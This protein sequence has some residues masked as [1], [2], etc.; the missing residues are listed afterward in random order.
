[1]WINNLAGFSIGEILND[2]AIN[3]YE[4]CDIK[5]KGIYAFINREL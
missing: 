4:R 3:S 1:M 2:T 5:Y